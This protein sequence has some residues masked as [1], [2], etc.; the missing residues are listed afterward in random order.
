MRLGRSERRSVLL[1]HP[2][3][4]ERLACPVPRVLA[5]LE[6]GDRNCP[7]VRKRLLRTAAGG[8]W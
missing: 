1:P 5:V 8:V 6:D 3:P 2:V 4:V 7:V